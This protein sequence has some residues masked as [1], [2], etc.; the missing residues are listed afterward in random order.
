MEYTKLTPLEVRDLINKY[1]SDL[2]KL[3]FQTLRTQALIKELENFAADA[4]EALS[5]EEAKIEELPAAGTEKLRTPSADAAPKKKAEAKPEKA[6]TKTKSKGKKRGRPKGSTS[7]KKPGRP[8]KK[9]TTEDKKQDSPTKSS[10]PEAGYRLSDWD[11]FVID[12]LK[13]VQSAMTTSDFADAAVKDESIDSGE[14]QIKVKLN[15]SL[16]KLANKKNLLVKVEHSGRG[17][18]YA[19]SDWLNN[20]GEL[21]KKYAHK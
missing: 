13:E 17:F 3:E 6:K 15:R 9:K 4:E 16:H 20:K 1:Q 18:A 8:P 21:P 19:L 12:R 10:S 14:A 7:K 2:R 5:L 11:Q